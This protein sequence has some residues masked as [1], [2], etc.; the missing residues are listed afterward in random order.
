MRV[1]INP[2]ARP[3]QLAVG[4]IDRVVEAVSVRLP[5]FGIEVGNSPEDAD[6]IA[7]HGVLLEERTGVP[8]VSHCHGLYWSGYEWPTWVGEAN[9]SV[10]ESMRRAI[11]V[12]APSRWVADAISRGMLVRP[13]VLPHGVDTDEWRP[14]DSR[15]YVLWNKAREDAVSSPRDMQEVA[16]RLS[17]IPFV[18]TFGVPTVNVRVV[19]PTSRDQMRRLVQSAGIYLGTVRETFGISV[20]ESLACGVPVV[21]WDFGG[22]REIIING[23]TGVLVPYGDYQQLQSAIEEVLANR[24]RYSRRAREDAESRW[25]WHDKVEKYADLYRRVLS[26]HRVPRPRVSVVVTTHNLA[27]FLPDA[28]R[29]LLDQ[30]VSDWEAI[31]VDDLS[32]TDDPHQVV[33]DMND[34]RIQYVRTSR[35]LK[36]SSARN[37][38]ASKSSGRYLIFLDADDMLDRGALE[39]LA[40]ALDQSSGLHIAYGLLDTVSEPGEGRSRNPWPQG[41]FDWRAQMSHLN[42]LPYASMMRREVFDRVGGYRERDWRAE[43]ASFWCRATSFGFRARRV[44]DRATLIYRFRSD[45][46]SSSELKEFPDRDGDWTKW[47]PWRTGARNGQEGEEVY[48]KKQKVNPNLVPFGVQGDPPHPQRS[49]PVHHHQNPVVS[50]VIPVGSKHRRYLVDA[51]DSCV[52]QTIIDWEA[53]VVDDSPE[54]S[55]PEVV[56]GHPFA[57]VFYSK[58]AGT[59]R[60]RNVGVDKSRGDFIFFLDADDFIEPNT[61]EVMLRAYLDRGGYIYSDCRLIGEGEA[62]DIGGEVLEALDYDQKDFLLRGYTDRMPG[63]HSV[64]V[65][66]SKTDFL[67]TGGFDETLA[68]WE[69]WAKVG[70][71]FAVH[72]IQGTRISSPLLNYRVST[73]VRRRASFVQEGTLREALRIKYQPYTAG[74]R[75]MCACGQGAGGTT[76]RDAASRALSVL[77]PPRSKTEGGLVPSSSGLVRLRYVGSRYGAVTFKG[78]RTRRPYRAGR[79]PQ[80][81]YVDVEPTDVPGLLR[82]DEFEVVEVEE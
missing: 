69:D 37:L 61:L 7:N 51:L 30:T 47:F 24:D 78:E 66:V 71:D 82:S 50:I 13:E 53:I 74:E 28:L 2:T 26:Q 39:I 38:G 29:S 40:D 3:E 35:N 33:R 80:S 58:G 19:G 15:G 76:A 43:D 73:G 20:L 70:L 65:L 67:G 27:R 34:T 14:G 36:L 46:K 44:T 11:A 57:R 52:A 42:Q 68:Y 8:M 64:S 45:S 17:S 16:Q 62:I 12:T 21:G 60:A 18:S 59:G 63:A 25:G 10:I 75:Q 9:R 1:Y 6:L 77:T 31:V 54:Q 5:D 79:E 22:Q 48:Y 55:L 72:G 81:E 41:E 32:T 23:E 56:A 49:W 4:G